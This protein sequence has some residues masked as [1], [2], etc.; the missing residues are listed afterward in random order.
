MADSIRI[1]SGQGFWGDLPNAPV[2]Q[3]RRGPIDYLVLDYLAEVTMSILQKQM[4]YNA[5]YGY[6]RDFVGVIKEILPDIHKKG[7]KVISNAGGMN[8]LACKDQIL[9]AVEEQGIDD[10]TVAVVEGDNILENIDR[11]TDSGYQ[12]NNMES[13]EPITAVQ[14]R[15]QSANAYLGAEPIVEALEQ[16]ADIV[17][18]GRVI[19]AGLT[20]APMAHEFGWSFDNYDK[21]A[22]GIIAGH[23]LECGAQASGGNYTD[24][25][26][27]DDFVDIGFPIIEAYSDGEFYVTK[28]GGTGGL[29]SEETVKEQL[30]YEIKDPQNYLMPDCKAD[31]TSVQLEADGPDRVRVYGIEGKPPTSTYKVSA[32]YSDGYK[33][34]STLVYSWP[35]ALAKAKR[36]GKVLKK[37][38][39]ALDIEIGEYRAEYIGVNACNEQPITAEQLNNDYSEILLRVSVSGKDE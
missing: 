30:V 36:A 16:D 17:I 27:V 35:R 21:M 12:L 10:I 9:K 22:T 32:S 34:S 5:D 8:P 4:M 3:V 37:R 29:V 25:E 7:I 15:L 2:K 13:G 24:W 1:A 31:F 20:L 28:H 19:D 14:D 18:T 38:A 23:L 26:K 6:A 11:L 33:L 39:Q